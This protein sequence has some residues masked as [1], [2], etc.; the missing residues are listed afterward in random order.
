M[1]SILSVYEEYCRARPQRRR[2]RN[3]SL[4]VPPVMA[5]LVPRDASRYRFPSLGR[6][7]PPHEEI[8]FLR[9]VISNQALIV[10]RARE[11]VR[12][13]LMREWSTRSIGQRGLFGGPGRW[14]PVG[15]PIR[16]SGSGDGGLGVFPSF[17]RE[18]NL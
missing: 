17:R 3:L 13:N 15:G 9:E 12:Q 18:P 6:R 1:A 16:N 8:L 14:G 11:Q 10:Q 2:P 4:S 5:S 7:F